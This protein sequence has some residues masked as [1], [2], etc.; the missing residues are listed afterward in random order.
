MIDSDSLTQSEAARFDFLQG[1]RLRNYETHVALLVE[2]Y[3]DN[4]AAGTKGKNE[5][6]A[7]SISKDLLYKFACGI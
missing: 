3:G 2:R 4:N 5:K 7:D 6:I 1:L